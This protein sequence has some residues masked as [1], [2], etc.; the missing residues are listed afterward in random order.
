[1]KIACFQNLG[2]SG[3][4]RALYHFA[5]GLKERGHSIDF[6]SFKGNADGPF[7][8]AL[9]ADNT[10]AYDNELKYPDVGQ[11]RPYILELLAQYF[12]KKAYYR[13]L[14]QLYQQMARDINAREYDL[15]FSHNCEVTQAP[16]LLRYLTVPSV[17]FA[18]EPL[19][20]IYDPYAAKFLE[21]VTRVDV[22]SLKN[23]KVSLENK[24]LAKQHDLLRAADETNIKSADLVLTNSFYTHEA[25]FRAYGILSTVS[26]PGVDTQFFKPTGED[27]ENFVLSVGGLVSYKMHDFV[28]DALSKVKS[29][30]RPRLVVVGPW[31]AKGEYVTFLKQYAKEKEVDLEI[32]NLITDEDLLSLYNKT[33]MLVFASLMEPLG[34]AP[35]EAMACKTPVVAVK[36][37][38]L[39]ETVQNGKNGFVTQRKAERYAQAIEKL[40]EDETLARSMGENGRK[41]V[42]SDWSWEACN[43]R[44]EKNLLDFLRNRS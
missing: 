33:K 25:I 22:N 14:N 20:S 8:P 30:I 3:A 44:L 36:E 27:H 35:L 21:P 5:K 28:I 42:E 31:G 38:G 32:K 24:W 23:F 19:R 9:A 16:F 6:Y 34:L 11:R 43:D 37:G 4:R 40:L 26:Q 1:M 29:D 15:V 17:Y 12:S 13:K 7:S 39:R 2:P 41:I 18:H 10:Y